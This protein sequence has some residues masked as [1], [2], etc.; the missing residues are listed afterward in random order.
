M[1]VTWACPVTPIMDMK[2]NHPPKVPVLTDDF[3]CIAA[4]NKMIANV[5]NDPIRAA[6]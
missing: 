6:P 2:K 1:F 5:I 3:V 4:P